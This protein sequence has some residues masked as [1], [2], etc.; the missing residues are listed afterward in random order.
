VHQEHQDKVLRVELAQMQHMEL[1]AEA[2][3]QVR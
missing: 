1:G 2:V 3:A